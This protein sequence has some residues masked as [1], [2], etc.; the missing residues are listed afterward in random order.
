MAKIT[1]A[2]NAF[3]VT[4]AKKLADIKEL[5]KY[6]PKALSLF[7]Q[8]DDGKKEE[9]FRVTA[10]DKASINQYGVTFSDVSRDGAGFACLTG[11]IPHNVE[12]AVAY[13]A[14]NYGA[15]VMK[16]NKVEASFDAALTEVAANKAAVLENI[17]VL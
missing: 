1:I 10:S 15:A 6:N 11:E 16:L 5:Q 3:V 13:I 8:N 12:N 9:V 4:S 7:E 14:D 2:G 17:A